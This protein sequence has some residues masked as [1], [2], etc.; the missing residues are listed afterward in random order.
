MKFT[1]S[2]FKAYDIRGK[3]PSELTHEVAKAVGRALADFLP[4]GRVA[5]GRDM[6]PDSEQLASSIAD[7]LMAQG[8]EV[9][10]LGQITSDMMYFAVGSNDFAGGA[11]VT[12]SHNPGEYNGIKLT[13][14]GVTPIGEETG[15]LDIKSAIINDEYKISSE[16]GSKTEMNI[17]SDWL[18]HTLA[19]AP[20]LKSLKIGIDAGN[21]MG[22]IVVPELQKD[23]SLEI[24]GLYL[25][26]DGTFP[27]HPAN[28]LVFENLKDLIDLVK[29]ENLDCGIAFDGDGDRAFLVD[30]NGEVVSGSVLGALLSEKFLSNNPGSTILYN[31]IA[32]R[33]VADTIQEMGGKSY[34]T[35][36]GHSFIKADMRKYDAVFA[37][38]HSGHFYFKDNYNADSGLIAALC[39]LDIMSQTGK[40]LSELCRPLREA[41]S[42][43]G[44]INFEASNKDEVIEAVSNKFSD[45]QQDRLDGLTVNYPDW[46]LNL[47]PSNTEPLLR[48][49]IE[50]K[51][52]EL[53]RSKLSE[54]TEII[55]NSID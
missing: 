31:A 46:W 3:V 51:N 30:E 22:G 29:K 37:C 45:G 15:L 26:P 44:E 43:S 10:D 4:E 42:D 21:G 34:R 52:S 38:E 48:L 41:Y 28:P 7:G 16:N 8:R 33:V 25:E 54:I 19:F 2:I 40:K 55:K 9:V 50:A 47:R 13:G 53:M 20:H 18:K 1:E 23:T 32:S 39:A 24:H 17:L 49:N 27:N 14:A 35:K 11:M 36:V 12:A 6:R 5:V